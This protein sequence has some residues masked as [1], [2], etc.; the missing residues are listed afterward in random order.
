[1][2]LLLLFHLPILLALLALLVRLGGGGAA[3]FAGAT[4]G[5][6]V[7]APPLSSV[8]RGAAVAD[9]EQ[10]GE[11]HLKV[12]GRHE[13]AAPPHD[14][15]VDE[16]EVALRRG[17]APRDLLHGHPPR[18]D[19][20]PL[21]P[22]AAVA[23]GHRS[24]LAERGGRHLAA[25]GVAH[26]TTPRAGDVGLDEHVLRPEVLGED[27]LR[28]LR[29]VAGDDDIVFRGDEPEEL[30]EPPCLS[31]PSDGLLQLEFLQV[32]L[33]PA[34]GLLDCGLGGD[35][36]ARGLVAGLLPFR[37]QERHV[38]MRCEVKIQWD[39]LHGP[40]LLA[41]GILVV[42]EAGE[43]ELHSAP[44]K[45]QGVDVLGDWVPEA[46]LP[47]HLAPEVAPID[48][49]REHGVH[50]RQGALHKLHIR[51][52]EPRLALRRRLLR[53]ELLHPAALV[54]A[55]SLHLVEDRLCVLRLLLHRSVLLDH[56]VE[57][58][59]ALVEGRERHDGLRLRGLRPRAVARWQ[60][61][62]LVVRPVGF[63][64]RHVHAATEDPAG[65]LRASG[66]LGLRL[67]RRVL[68]W[69][70]GR[71]SRGVLLRVV[72][73]VHVLAVVGALLQDRHTA[74]A[75]I[76]RP[77]DAP[78]SLQRHLG[79]ALQQLD[80]VLEGVVVDRQLERILARQV[81]GGHRLGD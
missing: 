37:V 32:L 23:E 66:L 50:H 45:V 5:L 42:L 2:S 24:R 43:E 27:L 81:R 64:R 6:Q 26:E 21:I 29:V 53:L 10:Q 14:E 11:A 62:E 58:V 17:A 74:A 39:H 48:L 72:V 30:L 68:R 4:H 76:A 56:C 51:L 22:S 8:P 73:L 63:R 9:V 15:A 80:D 78:Q 71:G 33:R 79:R 47:L 49:R 35:H 13:V 40:I 28:L 41:I 57:L 69:P 1:M 77:R 36:C 60:R 12:R 52:D 18:R 34:L 46:L 19:D 7:A 20:D 54:G 16:D 75:D 59:D 65:Q 38:G 55:D 25:A 44:L 70:V 31:H 3:A 61:H 67:L